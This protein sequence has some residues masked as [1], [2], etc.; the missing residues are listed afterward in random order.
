MENREYQVN[1]APSEVTAAAED[2]EIPKETTF[3]C[4]GSILT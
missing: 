1:I 2:A 3:P 4:Y